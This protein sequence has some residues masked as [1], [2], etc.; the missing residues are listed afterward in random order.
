M[1]SGFGLGFKKKVYGFQQGVDA[2]EKI[3]KRFQ[4]LSIIICLNRNSWL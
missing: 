2:G 4:I 3:G 1:R